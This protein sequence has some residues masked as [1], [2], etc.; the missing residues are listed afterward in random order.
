MKLKKDWKGEKFIAEPPSKDH[1]W[2]L[3]LS[4]DGKKEGMLKSYRF[5]AGEPMVQELEMVEKLVP[6]EMTEPKVDTV[7]LTAALPFSIKMKKPTRATRT[8][9]FL[10][11]GEVVTGGQGARVLGTGPNGQL[12]IPPDIA[13][14]LPAVM[15]LRVVGMNANGKIYAADKVIRLTQ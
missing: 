2:V 7:S 14:K 6:F 13:T 11:T 10:W 8:M 12:K 3:H 4:R 1:D 15:S 5:A 9:M